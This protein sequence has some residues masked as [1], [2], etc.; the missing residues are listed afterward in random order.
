LAASGVKARRITA[1]GITRGGRS[2]QIN[3]V[4]DSKGRS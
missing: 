1:I 2:T 3:A 4:V